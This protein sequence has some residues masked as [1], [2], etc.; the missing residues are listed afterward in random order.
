MTKRSEKPIS[1]EPP[2]QHGKRGNP[3]YA[4]VTGM[5]PA[6]LRRRFKAK[7]ALEGKDMSSVLEDLIRAYLEAE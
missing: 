5:V 4:Q 7:V 3:D 1:K 6:E 2:E